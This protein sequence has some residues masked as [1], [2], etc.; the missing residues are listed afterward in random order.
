MQEERIIVKGGR[1][2]EIKQIRGQAQG[3]KGASSSV[4]RRKLERSS[5][6]TRS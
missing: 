6:G 5:E 2:H 4:M 3:R 1:E